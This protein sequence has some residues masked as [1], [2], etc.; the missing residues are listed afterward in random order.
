MV[1]ECPSKFYKKSVLFNKQYV[2]LRY[3]I[4]QCYSIVP[5]LLIRRRSLISKFL[6]DLS[7]H[8]EAIASALPYPKMFYL[9]DLKY[10]EGDLILSPEQRKAIIHA[11]NN[12]NQFAAIRSKVWPP[13][14]IA[15]DASKEICK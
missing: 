1:G 10:F 11:T 9:I 6:L 13:T 2:F 3:I 14:R 4:C 5:F 15:W 12:A 8:E 7:F